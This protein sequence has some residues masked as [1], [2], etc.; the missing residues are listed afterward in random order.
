MSLEITK[1]KFI[2]GDTE[3]LFVHSVLVKVI[4]ATDSLSVQVHPTDEVAKLFG[5]DKGKS[6]F[7]YVLEATDEGAIYYGFNQ[8]MQK[9]GIVEALKNNSICKYINK[10]SVKA[11]DGFWVPAGLVHALLKGVKVLE[12]QNQV[13]L[14][15]RFYDYGRVGADGKERE[16]HIEQS[17]ASANLCA[18]KIPVQAVK[19]KVDG[20]FKRELVNTPLFTLTE[21]E[22]KGSYTACAKKHNIYVYDVNKKE[23]FYANKGG[24][25]LFGGDI[26]LIV[27][28][29]R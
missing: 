29:V 16:L 24:E 14:T 5:R 18:T 2:W 6:E 27:A 19:T 9:D 28:E 3:E 17:L 26:K 12:V 21:I 11:G 25:L 4:N 20:F 23:H 22:G 15:Y 7:W 13:D 10:I 1:N 8:N